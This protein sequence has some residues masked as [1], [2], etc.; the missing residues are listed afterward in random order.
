LGSILAIADWHVIES[1]KSLVV[2]PLQIVEYA[3][4]QACALHVYHA[5]LMLGR[6]RKI[7]DFIKDFLLISIFKEFHHGAWFRKGFVFSFVAIIL[8]VFL[9]WRIIV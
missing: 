5:G 6:L 8:L 9:F 3:Q 7:I 4:L 1:Y 2:R